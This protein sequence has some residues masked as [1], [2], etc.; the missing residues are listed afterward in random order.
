MN[1][2]LEYKDSERIKPNPEFMFVTIQDIARQLGKQY[3]GT[4]KNDKKTFPK[5]LAS[6]IHLITYIKDWESEY[7]NKYISACCGFKY[8]NQVTYY[9]RQHSVYWTSERY[10][11]RLELAIHYLK[12]IERYKRE[13]FENR[14]NLEN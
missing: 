3:R 5:L 2:P 10:R 1:R 7:D 8:T 14:N 11:I 4:K 6:F 13:R 12:K 9:R